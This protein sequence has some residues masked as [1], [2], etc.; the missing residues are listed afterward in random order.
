MSYGRTIFRQYAG[1]IK[2]YSDV[3][4][5]GEIPNLEVFLGENSILITSLLHYLPREMSD[6]EKYD[7]VFKFLLSDEVKEIAFVKISAA[8]YASLAHQAAHG[9]RK[10]LPNIGMASDVTMIATLLPYCDA[11]FIDREM[12]NL[13]NLPP[14]KTILDQYQTKIFSVANNDQFIE[15]LNEIR[16][17]TPES[18]FEIIKKVYGENWP[19]PFYTMYGKST[20]E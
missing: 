2:D 14:T 17:C 12:F 10:K 16:N 7:K 20:D 3:I 8:L 9:N 5:R 4:T 19:Q 15:Y 1:S 6:E 18:H 13:C 11:I